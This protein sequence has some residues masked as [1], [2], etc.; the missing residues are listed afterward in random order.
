MAASV[1][2]RDAKKALV[3][4]LPYGGLAGYSIL[5]LHSM[6]VYAEQI[7]IGKNTR[8]VVFHG[9]LTLS[10]IGIATY[11]YNR[12]VFDVMDSPRSKRLLWSI[13]GTWM[14]NFG[15]LM[16]WAICKEICPDYKVIRAIMALAS[17][18]GLVYV[19][20]DYLREVDRLRVGIIAERVDGAIE[21]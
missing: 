6:K 11:L 15:S 1:S 3:K 10:G 13:Y 17:S 14:F 18:A 4:Y 19:G 5:S 7:I 16:L 21:L 2:V 20:V 12:P 9:A 8:S